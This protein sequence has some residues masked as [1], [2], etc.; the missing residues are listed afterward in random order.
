MFAFMTDLMDEGVTTVLNNVRD[1]AGVTG[2]SPA[3]L[4]HEARDIFPHNPVRK[5]RF[6]EGGVLYFAPDRGRYRGQSIQPQASRLV[7]EVD[8]FAEVCRAAGRRGMDVNAWTVFL[9]A[10]R[11]GES[12]ANC[13]VRNAFD[14]PYLTDL[15]PANPEV[16][17]YVRALCADIARYDIAAILAES[18]H[19]HPLDHGYHHEREFLGLDPLSWFLLGLCF[20]EHCLSA[21]E[22]YG[23]DGRRL[24]EAVAETLDRSF[25]SG[26]ITEES[27][28][29]RESVA[30]LFADDL[31]GYLQARE[32]TV[33]SLIREAADATPVPI[34][35][36][37]PSGAWTGYETGSPEGDAAVEMAWMFGIDHQQLGSRRVGVEMIGYVADPARLELELTSYLATLSNGSDLGVAVRPMRPDCDSVENLRTKVHLL[38]ASGVSRVDYYHYGLA[39]LEALD[40][41]RAAF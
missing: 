8:V 24:Q 11:F 12:N 19:Y 26:R 37:D 3:V 25:G 13:V 27:P 5:V 6:L 38:R 15:C 17:T 10:D 32:H 7:D 36:I 39:R 23:V 20:C 1:R 40:L 33:A 28:L 16:R 14:D 41:I 34:V 31:G 4:Y 2:I 21:G 22:R 35:V 30:S 18:L 9:H 29:S